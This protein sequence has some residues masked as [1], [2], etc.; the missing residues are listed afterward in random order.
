MTYI[1]HHNYIVKILK[2]IVCVIIINQV[3]LGVLHNALVKKHV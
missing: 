3:N 2:I 1:V